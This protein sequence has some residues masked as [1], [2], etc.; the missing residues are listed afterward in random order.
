MKVDIVK[1]L[2]DQR[3]TSIDSTE[4]I[5]G[6][7]K[8]LL[9]T[10]SQKERMALKIVGLDRHVQEVERTRG[11]EIER[12]KFEEEYGNKVFHIDEVKEICMKYDLRL[13]ET[14]RF[15]GK[16]DA[17]VAYKLSAFIEAHEQEMGC[18]SNDF[19]IMAPEYAFNL[20]N[21]PAKVRDMDPVLLYRMPR[22][23]HYVFIHKWG[24]DFTIMR[25]LRGMFF[26]S[27]SSM[28][29]MTMSFYF[30]LC[31]LIYALYSDSFVSSPLQYFALLGIGV[32]SF[33]LTAATLGI[34]FGELEDLND[35]LCENTWK[36]DKKRRS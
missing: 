15:A 1:K 7:V 16:L 13:L 3:K 14:R 4:K 12:S 26:S 18:S 32:L 22:T 34:M 21:R 27:L 30:V 11:V 20:S 19:Y 2:N 36:S 5:V 6:E 9:D 31:S 10:H 17:Q 23:D 24:L 29:L 8:L 33:A 28:W 35:R 25:R